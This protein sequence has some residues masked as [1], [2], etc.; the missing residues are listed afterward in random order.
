[1]EDVLKLDPAFNNGKAQKHEK[2]ELKLCPSES[3]NLMEQLDESFRR[4][5]EERTKLKCKEV[6]FWASSV[7]AFYERFYNA[8]VHVEAIDWGMV[9]RAMEWLYDNNDFIKKHI[10]EG[11]DWHM[12]EYG[13]F[14][15]SKFFGDE[16]DTISIREMIEELLDGD[17]IEKTT[18]VEASLL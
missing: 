18:K 17:T 16:F 4:A 7:Y 6:R 1:M 14:D 2:F 5:E 8:G 12:K 13:K 15:A 3:A 9:N 11:W 10:E